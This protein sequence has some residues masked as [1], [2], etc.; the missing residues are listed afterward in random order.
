MKER[1]ELVDK[2]EGMSI[3]KQF[4]LMGIDGDISQKESEQTGIE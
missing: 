2:E 3:R 1:Q 4:R